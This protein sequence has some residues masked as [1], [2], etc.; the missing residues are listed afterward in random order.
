MTDNGAHFRKCDFQV[1]SPRDAAWSGPC[2]TGEEDRLGYARELVAACRTRGLQAIAVTDHHDM[3]FVEYVRRAAAAELRHDGL[4][5]PQAERLVVFPG[6]ELTLAVPCQALILFDADFPEEMFALAT[7]ALTISPAPASNARHTSPVIRL[8]HIQSL[9]QLKTELDKHTYLRGHYTVLPNV[10]EGGPSTLLRSGAGGKYVEMPWVGGYVDGGVAKLGQGNRDILD[11]KATA[12]GYKR[13]SVFQTSDS[14]RSDHRDLGKH[15]TW[16]KWAVPTAEALRQA[17]LAQESR[18]SHVEPS[19]PQRYIEGLTVTNSTFL[20]PVEIDFSPQYTA[21][22]GGRGTGKSTI[23]EYLRWGLCDQVPTI[24]D[25]TPRYEQ[26]RDHLVGETLKTFKARVDVRCSVNGVPHVVRRDSATGQ[27]T[28]KAGAEEFRSC[29][30]EELRAILPIQ[31]YSQKQLS[32]I[33]VRTSELI[34]FVTAPIQ[35]ALNHSAVQVGQA[36]DRVRSA[37]ERKRSRRKLSKDIHRNDLSISSLGQQIEALKKDIPGLSP[38]D[39][40]VMDKYRAY[41]N[42]EQSTSSWRRQAEEIGAAAAAQ[43]KRI[44]ELIGKTAYTCEHN[45][46]AVV[47]T[48]CAEFKTFLS[49]AKADL[50]GLSSRAAAAG[51]AQPWTEWSGALADYKA[52]YAAALGQHSVRSE[53]VT[54]LTDLEVRLKALLEE[55]EAWE[56]RLLEYAAADAEF[57]AARTDWRTLLQ[58]RSDLSAAECK[59]LTQASDGSIKA[60]IGRSADATQLLDRLRQVTTGSGLQRAK[61]DNLGKAIEEADDPTAVADEILADLERLAEYDTAQE[62]AERVPAAPA[63]ARHGFSPGDVKRIAEKVGADDWLTILLTPLGDVPTFSYRARE[64]EYIPFKN[65]SA[66][67]QATALLKTLLNQA[68]PPLL[69]DQPEDD[70]DNPVIFEI[71]HQLWKAKTQRQVIFASHN[72]NLVVNGDAEL[73]VWCDYRRQGDQSGG[74]IAGEG[75]IDVPEVREAIKRVMEGGE[76]AFQLRMQKYGF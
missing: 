69:I 16:V 70:L 35:D 13:I 65:A 22:I 2:P 39:R 9:K 24:A 71:V 4:P 64:G 58:Q 25:D 7:T 43:A 47:S 29:T 63:L 44:D 73:V 18:I 14:R 74:K 26:R 10:T 42:A 1:H 31:A 49:S 11:G 59:K 40:A 75:A 23:L 52:R 33:S 50:E 68:G 27:T 19:L 76:E 21:L 54:Q 66:G 67:Q 28:L 45:D 32:D 41:S 6:M 56:L 34:R 3:A 12:Y 48:M 30:E 55:K 20:G 53:K 38:E 8:D 5:V 46:L 15:S 62:G 37:Y 61:I 51:V 60:E 72:A 36:A 17:C 57:E